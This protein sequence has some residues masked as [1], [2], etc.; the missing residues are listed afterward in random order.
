MAD[1]LTSIWIPAGIIF[2]F[3]IE[4]VRWRIDRETKMEASDERVWLPLC[5][6]LNLLS[7][8]TTAFVVFVFPIVFLDIN[9]GAS[10]LAFAKYGVGLTAILLIGYLA[11]L[12]GHYR[13]FVGGRGPRP[14]VTAQEWVAV[15]VTVVV[16]VVYLSSVWGSVLPAIQAVL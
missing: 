13:L 7:M 8:A 9:D 10:S 15:G 11:A 4:M 3:Q 1:Q 14:L 16:A 2:A 5:D 12:T 6:Y